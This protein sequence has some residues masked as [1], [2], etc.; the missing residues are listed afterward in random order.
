MA[1]PRDP[2]SDY[3]VAIH[4]I[5]E[6]RYATTQPLYHK[7]DGTLA[8]KYIHWG[9]VD[10]RLVFTPNELWKTLTQD[11]KAKFIFPEGWSINACAENCKI[12]EDLLSFLN[13][14]ED[15]YS[16]ILTLSIFPC[17]TNRNYD[18]V[19]RWQQ[20]TK[21]PALQPLT[22]SYITRLTQRLNDNYRMQFL[23]AR[24]K[25][26][27][28]KTLVACDSTSRSAWGHCLADIHWGNNKDNPLL[29]NTVEVVVYSID[30]HEPVYY[31]TFPGNMS[32]L[33]TVRTILMD[34][35]ELGVD[36]L[37]IV[38]DRGYASSEN[39]AALLKENM[40]FILCSKV[41]QE[42]LYTCIKNIGFDKNGIPLY[43][44][45][46]QEHKLCYKQVNCPFK[47]RTESGED[48]SAVLK[49]NIYLNLHR[50]IEKLQNI[51]I[52][53]NAEEE[54]CHSFI[55]SIR[56]LPVKEQE[57]KVKDFNSKTKFCKIKFDSKGHQDGK[58]VNTE[59]T[60]SKKMESD[61]VTAGFFSSLSYDVIGNAKAQHEFY[62]LRD[63]QEKYFDIMKDQMGFD[64]Q[65]NWSE[66]GKS[67]RLPILFI[68]LILMSK[69][70]YIWQ[71]KLKAKFASSLEVL[72]E[73]EPIR[74]CEQ[75]DGKTH[76]TLFTQPQVDICN[77]FGIDPPAECLSKDQLRKQ[78]IIKSG[79][80]PGR[81]PKKVS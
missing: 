77:A 33:R 65:R 28:G 76:I 24:L 16:E 54:Q 29:E 61:T 27:E 31:R 10:E 64:I 55:E 53:Q 46:S 67:G 71:T 57:L 73:M 11:E 78:E 37:T 36:K 9:Q 23:K 6:Y 47:Y 38:F 22:S 40:P 5:R 41:R 18:R 4:K 3:R 21:V 43:M 60:Y 70:R 62:M 13:N 48:K 39:I 1:R 2:V 7:E 59:I 45:C 58:T 15:L 66:E 79:R 34:L 49:C 32:D 63:E 74:V 51:R 26:Q 20:Y 17:L 30:T 69:V 80:K 75:P 72:D 81:P 52:L 14:S 68:G 44:D 50:R 19:A 8:R 56:H 25:R 35:K 42:P 12:R